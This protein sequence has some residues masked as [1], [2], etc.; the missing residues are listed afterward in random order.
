MSPPLP[1]YC[2]Y[3]FAFWVLTCESLPFTSK[4]EHTWFKAIPGRD[5]FYL[6]QKAWRREPRKEEIVAWTKYL[7]GVAVCD[8]RAGAEK[9]CPPG[10]SLAR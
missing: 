7:R 4:P 2:A 8:T 10:F 1:R 9:A 3:P 6:V 5:S